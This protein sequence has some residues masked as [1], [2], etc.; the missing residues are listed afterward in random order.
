MTKRKTIV[1]VDA[2]NVYHGLIKNAKDAGDTG[3]FRWIDIR[4]YCELLRNEEDIIKIYYFS[5]LI[6][7]PERPSDKN[8]EDYDRRLKNYQ[9]RI[10]TII[11]Q[12][13]Y[14]RCLELN[15]V[16]VILGEFS[17]RSFRR[18]IMI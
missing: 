16:E 18:E 5:S 9:K 2:W 10:N 3:R 11:D 1:Y 8:P 7:E 15:G 13:K 17:K 6:R 12:K 4:K 14:L